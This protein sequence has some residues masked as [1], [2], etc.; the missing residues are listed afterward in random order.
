MAQT[1]AVNAIAPFVLCSQLKA[2]MM[3]PQP[4][5]NI[6]NKQQLEKQK[7]RIESFKILKENIK[8]ETPNKIAIP[9]GNTLLFVETSQISFIKGDG[10]Y[11]E[12]F[13]TNDVKYL[14]SRNLKNF[15][16]ILCL[17]QKFIRVHKSYIVNMDFITAFNKSDGGNLV[18]KTGQNIPVSS[19]KTAYILEKVALIKR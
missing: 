4:I 3:P 9:S 6:L 15:E 14:V 10:S 5:Q 18:L 19:D 12:I 11:S 7:Q 16:D 8:Q 1:M 2:I 13:C 17:D